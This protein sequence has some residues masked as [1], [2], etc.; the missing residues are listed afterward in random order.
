[1]RSVRTSAASAG[2]VGIVEFARATHSMLAQMI[3]IW[4]DVLSIV[5]FLLGCVA[6]SSILIYVG[7]WIYTHCHNRAREEA[8]NRDELEMQGL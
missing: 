8:Q 4:C 6:M 3:V 1:M 7:D 5:M 2:F